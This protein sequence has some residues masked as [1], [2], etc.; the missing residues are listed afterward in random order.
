MMLWLKHK[1]IVSYVRVIVLCSMQSVSLMAMQDKKTI[2]LVPS[3]FHQQ[4][5]DA[6]FLEHLFKLDYPMLVRDHKIYPYYPGKGTELF[7]DCVSNEQINGRKI[8]TDNNTPVSFVIYFIAKDNK[9]CHL[10]NGDGVM[11]L[12]GVNPDYRQKGYG[13]MTMDYVINWFRDQKCQQAWLSVNKKN[14]KA[15]NLYEKC[16]FLNTNQTSWGES[17]WWVLP[18]S[19][20]YKKFYASVGY[21][22]FCMSRGNQK[23]DISFLFS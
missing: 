16:G 2:A 17:C 9:L 23:T 19:E 10:K 20:E 7:R 21:K 4:R 14:P 8:L 18:L 15:Q 12:M 11:P 13:K 6:D 22:S 3:D 1:S 5:G